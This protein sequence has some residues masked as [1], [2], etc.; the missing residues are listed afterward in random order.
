LFLPLRR[1]RLSFVPLVIIATEIYMGLN[2]FEIVIKFS[3]T[4][5]HRLHKKLLFSA[6]VISLMELLPALHSPAFTQGSYN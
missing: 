3:L 5:H 4:F 1:A 6:A 2:R